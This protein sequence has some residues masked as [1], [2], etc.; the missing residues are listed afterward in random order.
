MPKPTRDHL[1]IPSRLAAIDEARRWTTGH[2]RAAGFGDHGIWALELALTEALSNVILHAYEGDEAQQ[3]RLD[4]EA[5]GERL[6]LAIHDSGRGFDRDAFTPDELDT[7]RSDGYGV[8]LIEEL[9]DEVVRESLPEGGSIL[10][11]VKHRKDSRD[12]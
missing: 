9:M 11:L 8:L 5:D 1:T 4:L 2:A 10:T 3:V 7:P 12:D 6:R